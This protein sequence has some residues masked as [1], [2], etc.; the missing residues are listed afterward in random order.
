MAVAQSIFL[1]LLAVALYVNRGRSRVRRARADE[2]AELIAA[3]LREW[4]IAGGE[5]TAL[6]VAMRSLDPDDAVVALLRVAASRVPPEQTAQLAA[7][8]REEAWVERTLRRATSPLWWRRMTAARLMAMAGVARDVP[9]LRQLL[10]DPNEAVQVIAGAALERIADKEAIDEVLDRLPGRPQFVQLYLFSILK[11][12][13]AVTSP[14]LRGRLE[15]EADTKRL[16]CWVAFADVLATPE[17]LNGLCALGRHS[18]IDVRFGV[19]QALRNYFHPLAAVTLT[20][21]LSDPEARVRTRA[22]QSLGSMGASESVDELVSKLNDT[23]WNVRFRSSIALAQLG[24]RGREA[25]LQLRES[26]DKYA[27]QMASM[28]TGLSPGAVAEIAGG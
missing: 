21:L 20:A 9:S 23:D 16:R 11:S 22:A 28:I 17:L 4:L 3:P 1:V 19:A 2:A 10:R 7:A 26:P 13:W 14:Q 25:L 18:D 8:M 12:Q 5:P 27:A 15:T 6:L 24:D